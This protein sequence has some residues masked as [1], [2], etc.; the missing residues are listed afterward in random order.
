MPTYLY[1]PEWT[2]FNQRATS[3]WQAGRRAKGKS[4]PEVRGSTYSTGVRVTDQ[5]ALGD[6]RSGDTLYILMHGSPG[7]EYVSAHYND[8]RVR[9]YVPRVLA[10]H[11]QM[12]GLPYEPIRIKMYSCGS[13]ME[14]VSATGA[15]HES[16]Y[17]LRLKHELVNLGYRTL[18]I[19]GYKGTA[20]GATYQPIDTSDPN[21]LFS[22]H[23]RAYYGSIFA[24]ASLQR[25]Q[26]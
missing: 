8:G 22:Q 5:G 13:G 20:L 24:R 15:V 23:R 17:A 18:S 26:V 19:Y 10:L 16:S 25:I 11:I 21:N 2:E 9:W 12:E 3:R 4:V 7:G 6:L 1:C 14:V